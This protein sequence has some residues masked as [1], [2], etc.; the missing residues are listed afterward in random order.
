MASLP[1]QIYRL[2]RTT[3]AIAI[4]SATV[5]ASPDV[6]PFSTAVLDTQ[7]GD[8]IRDIDPSELGL[9]SL[10][11]PQSEQDS[12]GVISKLARSRFPGAT[13]LKPTRREV[14][15]EVY[16]H[17]ALKYIDRYQIIR[18]M[19]RA[20][21]QVVALLEELQLT[22]DSIQETI[23]L[24][25]SNQVTDG[26]S[27]KSMIDSEERSLHHYEKK[28]DA[29]RKRV[30]PSST[31]SRHPY[32]ILQRDLLTT[33]AKRS[34][35]TAI[36][37]K[38]NAPPPRPITPVVPSR[39][40]AE[41]ESFWAT[42][43]RAFTSE[44]L[45]HEQVD[46]GELSVAS[47]SSPPAPSPSTHKRSIPQPLAEVAAKIAEDSQDACELRDPSPVVEDVINE[48]LHVEPAAT[49]AGSSSEPPAADIPL[50]RVPEPETPGTKARLR[51]N[52]EAKIWATMG[53]VIMPGHP[54]RTAG[55]GS[56]PP[57]AKQTIAH[58][59]SVSALVPTPS[60]PSQ[61]SLLSANAA[62]SQPT[63]HQI[64][65]AH[66]LLTLLSCPPKFSM[67]LNKLKESLAVKASTGGS[68]A[69]VAGQGTTRVL[70]GCVAKRLVK[71]ERGGGEQVVKF[72]V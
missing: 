26:P 27:I 41:E 22:R 37:G 67:P 72:D 50:T 38:K 58:L 65:T 2:S 1:D 35:R 3:K 49:P 54:Y 10:V 31:P 71:I 69:L 57:R 28:V 60:S 32:D 23:E 48:I 14:D 15:P 9:F 64:L 8:L 21:S 42:P 24:L 44:N 62:P 11:V 46:I 61:S 34:S 52:T 56:K 19:P 6:A 36:A 68:A 66:L 17:A 20:Y 12:R 13:P 7:L 47:M 5:A 63:P 18:P 40:D 45:L 59:Q 30:C 43:G 33:Q 4:A 39:A 70:Y 55:D 53:D 25:Q 51:I 16:A 29:L